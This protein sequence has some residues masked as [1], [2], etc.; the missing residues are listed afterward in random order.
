MT[1]KQLYVCDLDGTLVE[2]GKPLI[3]ETISLLN[4]ALEDN[5]KELII[6]SARNYLSIKRRIMGLNRDIKIISRN[7]SAIYDESGNIIHA[8][9]IKEQD[10][11]KAVNYSL[12]HNL[13]PVI[14]KLV[15]NAEA[16]YCNLRHM[17]DEAKKHTADVQLEYI[18]DF[19]NVNLQNVI[20]IY[21]FGKLDGT[22]NLPNLNITKDKEFLQ[23]SSIDADKGKALEYIK[24]NYDYESIT[25][26]GNDAND[27]P[28]LDIA[29][30]AYF[31]YDKEEDIK[32]KYNNIP[33]DNA[34][35]IVEIITKGGG[36]NENINDT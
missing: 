34:K 5:G 8:A 36:E 1:M 10:V 31:V 15:D 6:S 3:S 14:V 11:I 16:L 18:Q 4:T 17:N 12:K 26:F 13:C 22:Y 21:A 27:Y 25:C 33:F 29:T 32:E 2:N 35:G 20:G 30:N 23:I 28:M 24:N 9:K 7:G 19:V